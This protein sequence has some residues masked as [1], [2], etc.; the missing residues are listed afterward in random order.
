[1]HVR[2]C[3]HV[4]MHGCMRA[5]RHMHHAGTPNKYTVCI[6]SHRFNVRARVHERTGVCEQNVFACARIR[7]ELVGAVVAPRL[8]R[9][10]VRV[11][12]CVRVCVWSRHGP[13]HGRGPLVS[14]HCLDP[15]ALLD[16]L[17]PLVLLK[18]ATG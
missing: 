15:L 16:C 8:I 3:V 6:A 7:E 13:R 14:L 5:C 12:A 11:C 4:S 1:M 9:M 17:V 10:H 2:T 18:W